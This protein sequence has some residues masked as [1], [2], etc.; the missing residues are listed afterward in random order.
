M[1][2]RKPGFSGV[3]RVPGGD[4]PAVERGRRSES[5]S[6]EEAGAGGGGGKALGHRELR[7][8]S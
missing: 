3:R 5:R 8:G 6:S 4:D 2:P 7:I 1:G